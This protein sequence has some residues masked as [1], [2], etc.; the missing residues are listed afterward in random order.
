MEARR[1]LV[2][3][4]CLEFLLLCFRLI[5]EMRM[6]VWWQRDKNGTQGMHE[7]ICALLKIYQKWVK[8]LFVFILY[9]H[10]AFYIQNREMEMNIRL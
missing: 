4:L 3:Y 5:S 8:I 6:S 9:C 1:K 2:I 10:R 7:Q